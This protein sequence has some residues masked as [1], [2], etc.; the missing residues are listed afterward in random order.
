VTN[1]GYWPYE[2]AGRAQAAGWEGANAPHLLDEPEDS[3]R[4][5][6]LLA[7]GN[8]AEL[9]LLDLRRSGPGGYAARR[10]ILQWGSELW[11]VLDHVRD[12]AARRTVTTWTTDP[13]LRVIEEPVPNTFRLAAGNDRAGMTAIFATSD[14][15][16]ITALKG[17]REP[18][19]GWAVTEHEPGPAPAF[20]IEQPSLD[21]WAL[22]VWVPQERGAH[23]T[24]SGPLQMLEWRNAESWRVQVP[25]GRGNVVVQRADREVRVHGGEPG[26]DVLRLAL[27]VAPDVGADQRALHA[28]FEAAEKRFPRY[29]DLHAYRVRISYWLLALLVVQE[30]LY[31]LILRGR[32]LVYRR[33]ARVGLGAAWL[34]AGA[35][36]AFVYLAA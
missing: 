26:G 9:T 31:Y 15:S 5:A 16:R 14:G 10:Q 4:T 1:S 12:S 35:W 13:S 22:A 29:K 27:A 11:L 17:N 7:Y 2:L 30:M 34:S 28:A 24:A 21:S 20:R 36:L 8:G 18:F 6:D 33:M 19:A 23:P 32:F 3:A 25:A